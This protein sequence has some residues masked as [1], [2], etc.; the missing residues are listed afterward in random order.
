M[1][2]CIN[3]AV[4]IVMATIV[5]RI[6]LLLGGKIETTAQNEINAKDIKREFPNVKAGECQLTFKVKIV[7]IED[8]SSSFRL[9]T[10]DNQ[11]NIV[12]F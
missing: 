6:T 8:I 7:I 11:L 2:V 12:Y 4:S 1:L 3:E 9:Q 10:S 5:S